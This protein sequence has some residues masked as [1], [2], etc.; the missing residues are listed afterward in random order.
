MQT[1]DRSTQPVNFIRFHGTS[2]LVVSFEGVEHIALK[3]ICDMIGLDWRTQK[4]AIQE[5]YSAEFYGLKRLLPPDI[6]GLGGLKPPSEGDLYIRLNRVHFFLAQIN[7]ERVRANGNT[8]A[9]AW[10]TALHNE[11]A[12]A[13]HRYETHGVAVKA[14]RSNAITEALNLHKAKLTAKPE[15]RAWID[16]LLQQQ[17]QLLGIPES[18]LAPPQRQLPLDAAK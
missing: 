2:I 3:P 13:L 4:R 14:G 12:D 6:A 17:L 10:L 5:P 8:A 1:E 11:W 9:A 18:V 16:H 15:D 7:P